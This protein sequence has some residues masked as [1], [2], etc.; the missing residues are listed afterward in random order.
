[1]E[2]IVFAERSRS[3]NSDTF[4]DILGKFRKHDIIK[5][6]GVTPCIILFDARE[7]QVLDVIS[8]YFA[9]ADGSQKF[10]HITSWALSWSC[11]PCKAE[12]PWGY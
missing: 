3:G 7:H 2:K 4:S 1:M 11:R 10:M 5:R 6:H 12:V 9:E 8:V